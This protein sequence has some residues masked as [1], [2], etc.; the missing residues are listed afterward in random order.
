MIVLLLL[1]SESW[2]HLLL[3]FL[4]SLTFIYF[5]PFPPPPP[6]SVLSYHSAVFLFSIPLHGTRGI[7]RICFSNVDLSHLTTPTVASDKSSEPA[8]PAVVSVDFER[9]K[10][11]PLSGGDY[12]VTRTGF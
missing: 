1:S 3:A 6:L 12:L 4:S 2:T 9:L 5:L 10:A 7:R 8:R 11:L